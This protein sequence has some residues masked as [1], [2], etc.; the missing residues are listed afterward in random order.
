MTPARQPSP[1]RTW[2]SWRS[3]MPKVRLADGR[4]AYER[5]ERRNDPA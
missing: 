5:K 3:G 1:P 2:P 4:P